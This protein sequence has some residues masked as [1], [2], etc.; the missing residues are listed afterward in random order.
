M[1]SGPITESRPE[2]IETQQRRNDAQCTHQT[3]E[4][5][6]DERHHRQDQNE[7]PQP[8]AVQHPGLAHAGRAGSSPA[9]A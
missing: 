8:S 5:V 7:L 3:G 4:W 1:H 6:Q 2:P 9:A